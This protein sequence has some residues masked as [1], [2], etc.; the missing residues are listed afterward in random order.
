MGSTGS[1]S[2]TDYSKRKGSSSEIN[3]GGSSEKDKCGK[4][5]S[6][7]LEDVSRCFY[8]MNIAKVPIVGT[9]IRVFFN[10]VRVAVET[11]KGEEIGYL[12]TKYNYIKICL[13]DKFR[14]TGQVIASSSKPIPTVTVDIIPV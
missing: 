7:K 14:Y 8:F 9:E 3:D 2:F 4:G 1:G 5:F 10:G 11:L 12:P 6:T 13:S